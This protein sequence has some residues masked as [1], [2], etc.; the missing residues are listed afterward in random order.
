MI[1]SLAENYLQENKKNIKLTNSSSPTPSSDIASNYLTKAFKLTIIFE[2]F[3][4]V[5]MLALLVFI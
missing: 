3:Q 4:F 1:L 2:K 5:L